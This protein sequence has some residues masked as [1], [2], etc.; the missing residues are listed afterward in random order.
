MNP[1]SILQIGTTDL[2]G[3]AEQVTMDLHAEYLRRGLDSWV[4]VGHRITDDERVLLIPNDASR[5]AWARLLAGASRATA[6]PGPLRMTLA[7]VLLYLSDPARWSAV[8]TGLEDFDY[9]GTTAV[10]DLPPVRPGILHFH[11]LHGAYFDIRALPALTAR[12]PGV[13]TLHDAWVLTGHCAHPFE[14]T[15]WKTGCVDCPNLDTYVSLRR[16]RAAENRRVKCAAIR[17]SKVALATESQWL[18]G[19]LREGGLVAEGVPTAV[20]PNGVDTRLFSPA[21]KATARTELGL[22]LDREI[23]AFVG[24]NLR[25]N[26]FKDYPT[27]VE[28]LPRISRA[29][30][31]SVLLVALGGG[32][33]TD[34]S[35]VAS[36]AEIL[37]VPF[38]PDHSQ[39]ARYLCAADVYV[40]AARAENL[41]LAIIEAMACGAPVVASRVGGVPEVVAEGETGLL[42]RPGDPEELATAVACLLTDDGMRRRFSAAATRRVENHFTLQRQADAYL[43]FY[44]EVVERWRA[45]SQEAPK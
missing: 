22:P 28:A 2:G 45:G 1:G 26:P 41:P 5:S 42:V 10:P 9:P 31:S 35:D 15:G 44:E 14:C 16:D 20:I 38:S 13:L 12:V 27:L 4:A 17:D 39:V 40:H 8:L 11:N 25:N 37:H 23:V 18:M 7:R 29:R 21:D 34:F 24:R 32:S 19:M 33:P 43:A 36:S 3:G 30:G 6:A